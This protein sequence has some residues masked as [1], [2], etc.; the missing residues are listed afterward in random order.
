V[1][2]HSFL[3][4]AELAT[5]VIGLNLFHVARVLPSFLFPSSFLRGNLRSTATS[6]PSLKP[7]RPEPLPDK[8]PVSPDSHHP[9][10]FFIPHSLSLLFFFSLSPV[11]TKTPGVGGAPPYPALLTLTL[12]LFPL[13][14]GSTPPQC[15]LLDFCISQNAA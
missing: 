2:H 13:R 5:S 9:R 15:P 8:V 12:F 11:G 7:A 6:A 14:M 1:Y 3:P 10:Q 4:R